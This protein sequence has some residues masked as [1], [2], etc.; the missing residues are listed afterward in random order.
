[1]AFSFL[2]ATFPTLLFFFTLIPYIPIP[3]LEKTVLSTLSSLMPGDALD[4]IR[5]SI[6]D[7]FA[8]K[9]M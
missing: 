6:N 9:D 8:I 7:I 3:N 4:F 5:I 1:M 2:L